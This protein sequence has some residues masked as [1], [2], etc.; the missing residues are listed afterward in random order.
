MND[1]RPIPLEYLMQVQKSV[2]KIKVEEEVKVNGTGFFFEY[3][4]LHYLIT[5]N[6]IVS[7]KNKNIIVE[8]W[9]KHIIKLNLI[10]RYK[11]FLDRE[12]YITAIQLKQ[13]E[14]SDIQYLHYD[15][16]YLSDFYYNHKKYIDVFS[17]GY[18]DLILSTGSGI[19][20]EFN[21]FYFFHNIPTRKGSAGSPII[22]FDSLIVVGVHTSKSL[23]EKINIGTFINELIKEI[24]NDIN[25]KLNMSITSI[26][27]GERI[28]SVNFVTLCNQD[29]GHYS[30]PCK[31]IHSFSLLVEKLYQDFP[32]FRKKKL[33]F[34][35]NAKP[36]ENFHQT[37][38]QIGIKSNSVVNIIEIN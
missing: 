23:T 29:I 16:K 4:S 22:L 11:K 30:I 32:N 6:F 28:L 17:V 27:Q 10:N 9:N 21:D 31:N 12:K 24:N 37:L 15:Y 14:I 26:H 2:C 3:N 35:F 1:S 36:I 7:E 20:K 34:L 25:N 5:V 19:I 33:M 8:L 13:N 38:D 18:P